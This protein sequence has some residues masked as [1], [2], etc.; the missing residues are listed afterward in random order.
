M[1]FYPSRCCRILAVLAICGCGERF[2]AGLANAPSAERKSEPRREYDV[3]STGDEACNGRTG[4]ASVASAADACGKQA[5]PL[6]DAG[7]T[8]PPR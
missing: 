7:P 1:P 6:A 2:Q 5:A 3:I 4:G 8:P